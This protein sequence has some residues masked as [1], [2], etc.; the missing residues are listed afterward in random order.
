M[1]TKCSV[2]DPSEVVK[3][4]SHAHTLKIWRNFLF[5]FD[6]LAID[7]LVYIFLIFIHRST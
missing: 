3:D 6:T 1:A 5:V 7:G 4:I 2:L